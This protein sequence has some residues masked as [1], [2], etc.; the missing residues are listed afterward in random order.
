M[1]GVSFSHPNIDLLSATG[2]NLPGFGQSDNGESNDASTSPGG[3][4]NRPTPN[5]STA[6]DQ[7]Q[8]G[9]APGGPQHMT[10]SGRTS[11]DASPVQS[12]MGGQ[13]QSDLDRSVTAF[14]NDPINGFTMGGAGS[15]MTPMNLTGDGT[16]DFSALPET[17]WAN[18]TGQTGLGTSAPGETVLQQII[19]MGPMETMD[20]GWDTNP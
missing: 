17:A 11:F 1:Q 12:N 16:G 13:S 3:Q 14:F 5:S 9:L 18:M 15:G 19:R 20:L 2:G 8:T 6:S 4:S 7:R 10:G